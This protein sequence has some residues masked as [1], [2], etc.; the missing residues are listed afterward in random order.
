MLASKLLSACGGSE[1]LYVD[2]VFSTWLYTGNGSTQTINNGIDLAG[3]GGLVWLKQRDG[4]NPNGLFDTARGM[5]NRLL[6]HSTSEQ[7]GGF[8]LG[9]NATGFSLSNITSVNGSSL[10]YASWTFRKSA[11]FFDCGTYTGNGVA[12]RQIPHSLGVAP[13][14]VIVKNTNV[15][16]DWAVWHRSLADATY[17][18][19]NTTEA[20]ITNNTFN[21][22][23]D[24]A[25]QTSTHFTVG[26]TGS[27]GVNGLTNANASGE[28]YVW[29]AFAHDTSA[30]GIIQCGSLTVSA[31]R[32]DVVDLGFEAQFVITK[33]SNTA[34]PWRMWD[35]MRGMSMTAQNQLL[36][37]TS[38]AEVSTGSWIEPNPRGFQLGGGGYD[39]GNQVVYLAIR[40]PNKPPTTGT[41]VYN[42]IARTGTG[43]A[44]TVTGVGFAPDLIFGQRKRAS[45][46]GNYIY[47][48]LRGTNFLSTEATTAETVY[49]T[50]VTGYTNDGFTVGTDSSANGSG[51]AI[52]QQC[53]RRAPGVFDVVA[54]TGTGSARTV[55]HSLG[56][57]PELMIVK[58]RSL[59]EDW[60]AWHTAL[61][62]G[63]FLYPNLTTATATAANRFDTAPS[64]TEF[65]VG[66]TLS[67]SSQTYIAYLWASMPGISK[68][69]AYT[70]NGSSQ[71]IDCGFTAGARFF[72]VKASSTTGSWWIFDSV[73]GVISAAD[74]ALQLNSTA[75]EITSADACDPDA[76]GI[77][78]N[79]EAT[80]SINATGVSYIYLALS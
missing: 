22:F 41:Q 48:K 60:Y 64:V 16:R 12:G 39:A 2:D 49:S 36:A 19:L 65:S 56:A 63:K 24:G 77:I 54:Y 71:T 17:L 73:R 33:T 30:E 1:T 11:K 5:D 45:A 25:S 62:A 51:L 13:G 46:D 70:G 6:S 79:Q 43:A 74:P 67:S 35:S 44:A 53:F 18:K 78:V 47:D 28:E 61:G 4:T 66:S 20:A 34:D 8:G 32:N 15:A 42:A 40:R 69:G 37:N 31:G 14:M 3:K 9:A 58:R 23:G 76:S 7:F 75:A 57:V 27:S 21:V 26:K 68:V 72:L 80:C 52:I 10:S 55:N 59:S 29:Y 50:A 38:G